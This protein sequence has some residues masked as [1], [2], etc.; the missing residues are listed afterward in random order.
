ME[1][2]QLSINTFLHTCTRSCVRAND[3][4]IVRSS[5]KELPYADNKISVKEA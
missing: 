2:G 4:K 1:S 5:A 3:A